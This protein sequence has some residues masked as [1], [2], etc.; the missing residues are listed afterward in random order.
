M[1]SAD[2]ADEGESGEARRQALSAALFEL[3]EAVGAV[4]E[5]IA[6]RHFSL[7]E[8]DLHAVAS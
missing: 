8:M 7:V 3:I 4:S 1:A 2:V 5:R 6:L